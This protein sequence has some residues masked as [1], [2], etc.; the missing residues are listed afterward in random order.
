M[1]D[2]VTP[3]VHNFPQIFEKEGYRET[4]STTLTRVLRYFSTL[5]S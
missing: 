5:N 3:K 4:D 2:D 1:P